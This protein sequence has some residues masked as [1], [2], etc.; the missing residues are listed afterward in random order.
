M[1]TYNKCL[2]PPCKKQ[3]KCRGLCQVH[4][5]TACKLVRAKK[6]TFKKLEKSGKCTKA[7]GKKPVV[8]NWF[9]SK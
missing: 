6:I 3:A 9:L 7:V 1:K 8:V 5:V 2:Y 4:Y